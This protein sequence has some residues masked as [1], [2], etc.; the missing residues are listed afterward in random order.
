MKKL[1]SLTLAAAAAA[2]VT[3]PA[4]AAELGDKAAPLEIAEWV[5]GKPVNLA[6]GKGKTIY[7]V[8]FWATW[9]P[10]CRTSIPHLTEMQKKFKDQGVVFIGVSDEPVGKVKPF[11]EKMGEK[12]DYVVAVDKDSQTSKGYMEAFEI[13]GIPH[14]FIV[15][16]ESRV[17]WQGHPMIGLEE[18]VA[19]VVAGKLDVE[20]EKK[21]AAAQSKVEAFFTAA[22]EGADQEKLDKMAKELEAL[23][24]EVGGL[25][26]GKPFKADEVMKMVNFQKAFIAYQKAAQDGADSE[27]LD[28]LFKDVAANAPPDV[29]VDELKGDLAF[30]SAYQAFNSALED[31]ADAQKLAAA[32]KRLATAKSKNP[33][34]LNEVA[35]AILD[36]SRIKQRNLELALQLAK[37]AVDA[38]DAKEFAILDTYARA[39]FETGKT[40]DAI[41][42]QQKAVTLCT[43]SDQKADLEATL[44][45]Y[46]AAKK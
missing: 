46:Q 20:K 12:M 17:V 5:K 29:K 34:L 21:K 7:V 18:A 43:E 33:Q 31:G 24:K 36:D 8:E 16:K 13:G 37:T 41:A 38:S 1:L 45:K 3:V 26:Q 35:W 23:D 25:M 4:R 28:E 32:E 11:V 42:Q 39:L 15:D 10:P 19:K 40:A 22:M 9:C 44:R 27:K 30:Q 2:L 6:D 14:A